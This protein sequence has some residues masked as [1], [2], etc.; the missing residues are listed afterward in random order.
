MGLPHCYKSSASHWAADSD[1]LILSSDDSCT[2]GNAILQ[3][4]G[5]NLT[6]LGM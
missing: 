2:S 6:A 1:S 4:G 3:K 5:L